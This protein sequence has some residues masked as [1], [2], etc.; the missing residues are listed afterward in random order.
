[1]VD[2]MLDRLLPGQRHVTIHAVNHVNFVT[3]ARQGVRQPGNKYGIAAETIRGIKNR[4]KAKPK[5]A[6][7]CALP[8]RTPQEADRRSSSRRAGQPP[9][10][11]RHS[12]VLAR[13]HR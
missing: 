7:H 2:E 3:T 11:P 12:S 13:R 5:W 1:M 8:H 6:R 4:K 10:G 9:P